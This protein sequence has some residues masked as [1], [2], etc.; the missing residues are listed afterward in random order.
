MELGYNMEVILECKWREL[1]KKDQTAAGFVS[2][3]NNIWV[4]C[5]KTPFHQISGCKSVIL[6]SCKARMLRVNITSPT[7]LGFP[8]LFKDKISHLTAILHLIASIHFFAVVL[9]RFTHFTENIVGII[10]I[11]GLEPQKCVKTRL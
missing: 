4:P 10:A 6:V 11:F 2:T 8:L 5:V 3:F 7:N 9:K 1:V